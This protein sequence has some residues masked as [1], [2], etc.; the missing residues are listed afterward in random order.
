M[1]HQ[2]KRRLQETGF[3]FLPL[4]GE[5]IQL[6]LEDYWKI[7]DNKLFYCYE[8]EQL[9]SYLDPQTPH[10]KFSHCETFSEEIETNS[11]YLFGSFVLFKC[12]GESDFII[13]D[14]EKE[15]K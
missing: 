1:D 7:H 6:Q 10:T 11:K 13:F 4:S 15:I 3:F 8:A 14:A 5:S 9:I 12:F 2:T